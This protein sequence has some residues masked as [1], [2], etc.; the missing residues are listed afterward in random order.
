MLMA[1]EAAGAIGIEHGF[2]M[3]IF[4]P[5]LCAFTL[6]YKAKTQF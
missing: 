6:R 2:E 1:A 5:S 3:S 4:C